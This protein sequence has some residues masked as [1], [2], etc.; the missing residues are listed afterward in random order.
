MFTTIGGATTTTV[1]AGIFGVFG[2]V[3]AEVVL[4]FFG[5]VGGV[6]VVVETVFVAR[7]L[8]GV[9]ICVL[10]ACMMAIFGVETA[11]EVVAVV[12]AEMG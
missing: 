2:V 9:I 7:A 10:V 1:F 8:A 5:G 3:V 4:V 11:T 6:V 12:P